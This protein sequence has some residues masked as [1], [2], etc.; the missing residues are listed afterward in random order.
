MKYVPKISHIVLS[1][2]VLLGVCV[3]LPMGQDRA[4]AAPPCGFGQTP[5]KDNCEPAPPKKVCDPAN[6]SCATATCKNGGD[7]GL[8]EK[9]AVPVINFL[10][11]I[12]GIV[13]AIVIIVSGIQ[14]SA[15]GDDPGKVAAAKERIV[16]TV[17]AL[18]AYLFLYSFLQWIVPGGFL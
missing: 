10:A 5:D 2:F 1:F 13:A 7:C 18:L 4:V 12:V 3:A 17:I 15:S 9:Y 6:P 11:A 8:I 14:Y 16:N